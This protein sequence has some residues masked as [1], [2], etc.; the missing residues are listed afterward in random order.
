MNLDQVFVSYSREDF[1]AVRRLV[2][3]LEQEGLR[4]WVD[5]QEILPGQNWKHETRKAIRDSRYFLACCSRH[6]VV[7]RGYVHSE[8]LEAL[9]IAREYPVG[10]IHIIPVLLDD[11]PI[12]MLPEPLRERH[13]CSPLGPRCSAEAFS[14]LVTAMGGP[15]RLAH[16]EDERARYEDVLGRYHL[17]SKWWIFGRAISP[18]P[19]ATP[20]DVAQFGGASVRA[21]M[22][23]LDA[24]LIRHRDD[25]AAECMHALTARLYPSPDTV[26]G[27]ALPVVIV[28]GDLDEPSRTMMGVVTPTDIVAKWRFWNAPEER[29][30]PQ[31]WTPGPR[32]V[33]ESSTMAEAREILGDIRTGLPVVSVGSDYVIG[34]LPHFGTR[35]ILQ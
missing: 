12:D 21:Y 18:N 25:F 7:S 34:F 6:S 14:T 1:G 28:V 9:E 10:T 19:S 13:V 32:C 26:A 35:E 2:H 15:R 11:V 3:Q 33:P 27:K 31:V 8:L 30:A 22:L 16:D 5:F 29:L 20:R 24:L 23:G 4:I 17:H